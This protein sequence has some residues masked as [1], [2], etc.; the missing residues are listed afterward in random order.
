MNKAKDKSNQ[1]AQEAE[2]KDYL[3]PILKKLSLPLDQELQEEAAISVT[4]EALRSLKERL[5]TRAEIIQRRL[6]AERTR[7]ENAHDNLSRRL[8]VTYGD[9]K[10]EDDYEKQVADANFRMEILTERASQHYKTS[11]EKFKKLD[12]ELQKDPRLACLRSNK[13]AGQ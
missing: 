12:E 9:K 11:L 7:L 1:Q 4:N 2:E 10:G 8:D 3:I 13:G 5:L 6:E